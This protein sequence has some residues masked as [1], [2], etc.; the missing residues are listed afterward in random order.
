MLVSIHQ[1]QYLPWLGYFEK[2]DRADVFVFLDDVQFAKNDWQN[3]N[4]IRTA[5]GSQWLTVPVLHRFG[6][7]INEVETDPKVDWRKKHRRALEVSYQRAPFFKEYAPRL[8]AV[9]SSSADRLS[10]LCLDAIAVLCGG[11][12]LKGETVVSSSMKLPETESPEAPPGTKAEA[13]HRL[14]E[15]CKHFGADAYLSGAHG[16][17][18]L[19]V[20]QFANEGIEVV[21]QEYHHPTY[22]QCFEPFVPNMSVVDLLFNVGPDALR[23]IREGATRQ[24]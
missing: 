8:E 15:I 3:R 21:F 6:Q 20:D 1:P 23:V 22:A 14:V 5:Q 2:M 19:D 10:Q 9:F 12:G 4:K 24:P 16:R 13:T 17:H 11:L 7:K 18:Y